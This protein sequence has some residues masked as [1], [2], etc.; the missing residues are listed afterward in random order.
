M[1]VE[2]D[3]PSIYKNGPL[4]RALARCASDTRVAI[5]ALARALK[6]RGGLLRLSDL[7][8]ARD[9]QQRA[10]TDW[11][12]G[13]KRA[14]SPPPGGSMHEAGRAIDIDLGAITLDLGSFW[15]IAA[16]HGFTPVID[17]PDSP[18]CRGLALRSSRQFAR[19]GFVSQNARNSV[20]A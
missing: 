13:R 3:V 1:L 2:I 11:L 10:H 17:T 14:Y 16:A 20:E 19:S 9:L 6:L 8:R 15:K 4:P 5:L 12:A 7:F 18:P